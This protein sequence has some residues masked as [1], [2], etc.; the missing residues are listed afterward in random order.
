MVTLNKDNSAVIVWT[1]RQRSVDAEN[2]VS[3]Q[4]AWD[5]GSFWEEAP[6]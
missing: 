6:R 3:Y 5:S 4:V 2:A 1:S